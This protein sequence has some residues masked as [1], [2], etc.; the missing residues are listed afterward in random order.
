M[1]STTTGTVASSG[2]GGIACS[3]GTER[4]DGG[5]TAFHARAAASGN[6]P[7]PSVVRR[8]DSVECVEVEAVSYTH[9]T[10]PTIYSV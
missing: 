8:L 6:A 10:L 7:S 9:L 1:R 4:T 2:R 3:D 5:A